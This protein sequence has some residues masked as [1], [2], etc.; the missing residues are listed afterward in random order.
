METNDNYQGLKAWYTDEVTRV[1]ELADTLRIYLDDSESITSEVQGSE[2]GAEVVHSLGE[3][4]GAR[5]I[6]ASL[7]TVIAIKNLP[8][9]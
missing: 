4:K 3:V 1:D 2:I 6:L 7:A 9:A 8:E 5:A